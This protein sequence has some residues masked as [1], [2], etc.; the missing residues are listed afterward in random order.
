MKKKKYTEV[1]QIPRF[2]KEYLI[3]VLRE[4]HLKNPKKNIVILFDG[5]LHVDKY[6]NRRFANKSRAI[7]ALTREFTNLYG[8]MRWKAYSEIES[9]G[10]ER[11]FATDRNNQ[12]YDWT[13]YDADMVPAII[14]ELERE[15]RLVF[16]EVKDEE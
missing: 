7:E 15:G 5:K 4:E 16:A 3:S 14:E 10:P 12:F 13:R 9:Q 1:T 2:N 6:G 8:V 11:F